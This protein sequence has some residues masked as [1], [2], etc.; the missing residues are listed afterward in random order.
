LRCVD[1]SGSYHTSLSGSG[2]CLLWQP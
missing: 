2:P 1:I